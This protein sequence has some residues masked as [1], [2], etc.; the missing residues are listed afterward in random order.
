MKIM[1]GLMCLIVFVAGISVRAEELKVGFFQWPPLIEATDTQ[2]KPTGLMVDHYEN[3]IAKTLGV[4][5]TWL[6]PYPIPRVIH[7]LKTFQI[8]IIPVL[9]KNPDREKIMAFPEK[10]LYFQQAVVCVKN[11]FPQDTI[12]TWDDLKGIRVGINY[13]SAFHKQLS[14]SQP[15]LLFASIR[16]KTD[17][18]KYG[19][20]LV[21]KGNLAVYIHPDR[22]VAEILVIQWN[23]ENEIKILDAPIQKR[24]PY[25]AIS[26][27]RPD[28]LEKWNMHSDEFMFQMRERGVSVQ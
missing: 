27:G 21:L 11:D 8:D 2:S 26:L 25:T 1:M 14:Q 18:I 3:A 5:I 4:T 16:H 19:L 23:L 17:P 9:S 15:Q 22:V 28:L 7:L 6:G 13:G 24:T 12:S 10:P 20:E